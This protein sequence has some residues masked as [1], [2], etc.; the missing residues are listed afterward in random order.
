MAKTRDG[1]KLRKV[2]QAIEQLPGVRVKRGNSHPY[3]AFKEGY[4]VLC[5]LAESTDARRMI[6]PWIKQ[7]LGYQNSNQIYQALRSGGWN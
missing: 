4:A 2:V 6:V 1:L 5:P 7:A 3:I